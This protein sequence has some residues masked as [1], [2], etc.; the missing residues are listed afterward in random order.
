MNYLNIVN[1]RLQPRTKKELRNY[2]IIYM[3][4]KTLRSYPIGKWDVSL[5]TDMSKLF[6]DEALFYEDLF[7]NFNEDISEWD[8]SNVTNMEAMFYAC[9]NFNKPL[10]NWNVSNVTNMKLMFMH[11]KNFNQPLNNWNVSKVTNMHSMFKMCFSFNQPL[12]NWNVS[13][14]T[15][16]HS[17]FSECNNFNQPLNNW[18]VSKVTDMG[19][20]FFESNNFNQPL[21]WR[22]NKEVLRDNYSTKNMFPENYSHFDKGIGLLASGKIQEYKQYM[23]E[24]FTRD[25]KHVTK[26]L[27]IQSKRPRYSITKK[28]DDVILNPDLNR[29]I[30]DF[31]GGSSKSE[32]K[33][34][35]RTM[36]KQ[37]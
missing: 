12:N 33:R 2:L 26:G 11:C 8:V 29:E 9:E 10:N 19:R 31:L 17:M 14:V 16:M 4:K 24:Y 15:N 18:N 30:S 32:Q 27:E 5:I 21:Y 28:R 37:T 7:G 3:R 35:K 34:R 6:Y 23:N 22:V 13:K 20:M 25:F 1:G 36:K